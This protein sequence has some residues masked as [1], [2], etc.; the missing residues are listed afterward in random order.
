ML[1]QLFPRQASLKQAIEDMKSL[2]MTTKK[3]STHCLN[4]IYLL[5]V[6]YELYKIYELKVKIQTQQKLLFNFLFYTMKY[7]MLFNSL[8]T[9]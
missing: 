2:I 6:S 7:I 9:A 5:S 4:I 1:N 8:F 3:E